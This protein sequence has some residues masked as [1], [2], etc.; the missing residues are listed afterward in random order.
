MSEQT[1]NKPWMSME[2]CG[3]PKAKSSKIQW[4]CHCY[5]G[6]Y[7]SRLMDVTSSDVTPADVISKRFHLQTVKPSGSYTF[8]NFTFWML[9]LQDVS[10]SEC[11]TIGQLHLRKFHLREIT[12]LDFS[13]SGVFRNCGRFNFSKL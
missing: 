11:I 8:G 6:K 10:L 13:P 1:R 4:C 12:P 7:Y 9:H 3:R 2:K 5:V